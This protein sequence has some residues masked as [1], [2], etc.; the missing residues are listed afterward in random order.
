MMRGAALRSV[1]ELLGHP[2]MTMAMR[3]AH[4][5]PAFLTAEVRLLDPPTPPSPTEKGKKSKRAR[6]RQSAPNADQPRSEVPDF[7]RT[8]ASPH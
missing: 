1:A 2:S 4:L 3:Y 8:F 5:S 6:I 7:V